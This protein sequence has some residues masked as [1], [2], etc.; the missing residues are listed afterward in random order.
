M[1][2][3]KR[4]DAFIGKLFAWHADRITDRENTRIKYTDDISCIRFIH[5]MAFLC[6][7]LL[8]LGKTLFAVALYMVNFHAGIKFTGTDAHKSDTVTMCLVHICLDLKYKRREIFF[9]RID[10]S[11]ICC[12]WKRRS[13]H[14]QE[15]FQE[16]LHTEVGQCRSE[17]Y[18]RKFS[19]ADQLLV[20]FCTCSVQKLDLFEKLGFLVTCHDL[21]Q[22]RRIQRDLSCLAF[23]GTFFGI[24]KHRNFLASTLINT[25][26]ILSGADRPVDRAGRNA[27]LLFDVIEQIKGIVGITVHFIDKSKNRNVSHNADLEQLSGL[28]LNT[29]GPIDYHNCR[30]C[31]HQGTISIL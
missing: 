3:C 17:K 21:I 9:D 23:F 28:C 8:R 2:R 19:L 11:D 15:M 1:L 20:K 22:L 31:S 14:F 30:I 7:H 24:G 10:H 16:D 27:K 12:S 13:G 18:R 26:E 5:N 29:L 6:H 25:F 4:R